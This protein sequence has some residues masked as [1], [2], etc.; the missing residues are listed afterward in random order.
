MRALDRLIVVAGGGGSRTS[1]IV[2][3]AALYAALALAIGLSAGGYWRINLTAAYAATLPLMG[4]NL[5]FGQL[6][7]VSLCQFALAGVGGWATLRLAHLGLPFEAAL[8][9][10]GLAACLVGVLWGLPALRFRGVSLALVTLMLAGAFQTVIGSWNFPAGGD[11]FFGTGHLEAGGRKLIA[12]PL[13]APGDLAYFFY[14]AAVALGAL[15]AVEPHRTAKPG[16][17]WALISKS[18]QLAA[19]GGVSVTFYQAWAFALAGGLAGVGGGLLAGLYRQLDASAFRAA[20]SIVLFAAAVLGGASNGVGTV[21][22]G[23]LVRF[24]PTLLDEFGASAAIGTAIFGL[25]LMGAIVD[26]PDGL[27]GAFDRLVDRAA[28][29]TPP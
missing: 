28:R 16:R 13:L 2:A 19:C 3:M 8:A 1:Q 7:L 17:A 4:V 12:R 14:V 26:S 11:G 6:G 18:P 22:G 29:R 9:G 21:I 23:L 15:I 10:G 20:E 5:L 24:V 27:A 25:A